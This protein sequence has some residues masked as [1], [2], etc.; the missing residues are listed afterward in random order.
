M[1]RSSFLMARPRPPGG[2]GGGSGIFSL[3]LPTSEKKSTSTDL[4]LLNKLLLLPPAG[5]SADA[6]IPRRQVEQQQQQQQQ[7][8]EEEEEEAKKKKKKLRRRRATTKK[9][10]YNCNY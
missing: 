4:R 7:L 9:L 3:S 6:D 10:S 2:L 8:K 1:V 5:W